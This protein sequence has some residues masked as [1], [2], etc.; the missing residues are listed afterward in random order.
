MA[1]PCT[2]RFALLVVLFP[3]LL[4]AQQRDTVAVRDSAVELPPL[5]VTATRNLREVF[6]TP[7]PVTVVD[8]VTLAGRQANNAA[9][10][11]TDLAGL[12]ANGTGPNQGRPVIRGQFGQRILLLEDGLRMNN[13]RRQSDF[14]ELPSL[15]AVEALAQVEVVR[16]PASV[17]YGS[18]ALGGVVNLITRQPPAGLQGSLVHGTAGVRYAGAGEQA[19]PWGLVA[20]RSGRVSYTLFG[21][22][23]NAGSYTAPS[24]SFGDLRAARDLTVHDTGVEDEN[25]AVQLGYALGDR[26]GGFGR[27]ERYVARDAGFGYVDN[28]A[29]GR[30]DLPFI[31]ISY[32]R[33]QVDKFTVGYDAA[34]LHTPVADRLTVRWYHQS[35]DRLLNLDV[36]VP[37]GGGAPPGSGVDSRS[38]NNTD[39]N[40]WGF[41][42][43]FAKALTRNTLLTYGV[44][45]VRDRSLNSDS[46][47]TTVIGFGPPQSRTSTTPQLP[48]A[49]Y[50]SLGAFAQLQFT[51]V[52]R[53]DL[54]AGAR[55]QDVR[56]ET[57]RTPGL[58]LPEI[59]STDRTLVGAFN[60]SYLL[61]DRLALVGSVGRGFRSPN[62]IERFFEGPTP[63]GNG[64]QVR[65]PDLDPETSLNL[66]LGLRWRSRSLNAEG[67][68]F[69]TDIR[70]GIRIEP[71]GD[72]IQGLPAFRNTNVARLRYRGVELTATVRLGWGVSVGGNFTHVDAEDRKDPSNPIAASYATKLVGTAR[73][74]HPSGRFWVAYL[75]RHEG[76]QKD[77][78]LAF[79]PVGSTW[80]GFTVHEA[81]AGATLFRLGPTTHRAAVAV[82]NLGDRL[83]SEPSNASLFRP[84]PG[85]TVQASYAIDF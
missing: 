31:R 33:Q 28:A 65:T 73:Y 25:Y 48:Y 75:V 83:Y 6:S 2:L 21:A 71:T 70:D 49:V 19:R 11:L 10:L 63:E 29:I 5:V 44:D 13:S 30:P 41:R 17:L 37:F 57:R 32:P 76:E 69:Q 62:L 15:V 64:Y 36:F 38:R 53:L 72:T 74:D 39:V 54:V 35:N 16:G 26:H 40:S 18:D 27:Y 22:Y 51:P 34:G 7:V 59:E 42:V 20:G 1:R 43:E 56:A 77:V 50:R 4:R 58:A 80:P 82:A 52:R 67:F 9:E 81:R 66:D 45:G 78:S 61:T 85:R 8:S 24:G 68:V 46:V 55:W 14:G 23:R 84:A 60:A 3:S 47:T 79:S 12:D